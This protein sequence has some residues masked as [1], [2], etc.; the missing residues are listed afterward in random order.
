[1][2]VFTGFEKSSNDEPSRRNSGFT[3]NPNSAATSRPDDDASAGEDEGSLVPEDVERGRRHAGGSSV[4]PESPTDRLRD[5]KYSVGNKTPIVCR[6]RA[7][8]DQAHIGHGYFVHAIRHGHEATL[9][10][11]PG[12]EIAEA[13]FDDGDVP[14]LIASTLPAA[15]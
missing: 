9:G 4:P 3:A 8:T 6:R 7:H 5:P 10:D 1:M 13:G 14:P 11:L 12:N 2:T 15:R